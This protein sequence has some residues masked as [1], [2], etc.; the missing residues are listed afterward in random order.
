MLQRFRVT[1]FAVMIGAGALVALAPSAASAAPQKPVELGR[2]LI[3]PASPLDVTGGPVTA[4]FTVFTK[5]ADQATLQLKPP[6][7]VYTSVGELTR[8]PVRDWVKWTGTKKF[9]T[10]PTGTWSYLA[11]AKGGGQE[12]TASGTFEVV[13][14]KTLDTK[15]A[16]FGVR[17]RVADRGDVVKVFGRLLADSKG[18]AGQSVSIQF[19]GRH[20]G[21]F[22]EVAKTTT[23]NDGWFGDGVRLRTSGTFRAV[24]AATTAAKGS[25]SDLADVAVRH[26]NADSRIDGFD[27]RPEPVDKGDR[28]TFTGTLKAERRDGLAGQRV[29]VSF[30]AAGSSRWEDVT[31][32]VT[33][34][35]GRF[36]AAA[37]AVA[38]GW[39]RAEYAG[40]RGVN[41]SVSDTDWVTVEQPA[42]PPPAVSRADSRIIGF[43]A[44]AEPV[45]RGKYL[46][47][48]GRLQIADDDGWEG[49]S[50]KVALY[51]K[52]AGSKKWEYVKM[53]RSGDS[54]R[55]FA[56]AK[57]WDS[58]RWKFVFKG[59]DDTYGSSSRTDYVRVTR[60]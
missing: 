43:N 60:R 41:G 6:V 42:P 50:G 35:D 47:F 58:G 49:Y 8:T 19:R 33:G 10:T 38:S 28:L 13:V 3:S 46:R 51:F 15:F 30:R 55:L 7:G 23:G 27:V 40:T 31:S 52:K 26:R 12:K 44:Y 11:T 9:E 57:A 17:P 34:R 1:A 5:N 45:K 53:F 36:W 4:T 29:T 48:K 2:V 59:D 37:T 56:K 21:D 39:W 22:R 54:G 18:Y 16:S 14:K 20:S 32:T 25:V 24:F